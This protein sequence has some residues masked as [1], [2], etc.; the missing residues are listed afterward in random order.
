MIRNKMFIRL[1]YNLTED[2]PTDNIASPGI[3]PNKLVLEQFDDIKKRSRSNR[4]SI[5]FTSHVGTHIDSPYHF[6]ANGKKVADFSIEDYIFEKPLVVDVKKD[7]WEYII[8]SDLNLFDK[9]ITQC[10]LLMVRTMFSKYRVSDPV[11]YAT[12]NPGISA[13]TACYLMEK[14]NIRAIAIDTISIEF[15]GKY[16]HGFQAHRIFLSDESHSILLIE[17]VN[18]NFDFSGLARVIALPL[19]IEKVDGCP[20]TILAELR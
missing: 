11:R 9:D 15:E 7:N 20:C 5:Q 3:K 1:S 2:F 10:D 14:R 13:D 19:F 6:N 8:P 18:L 12:Q 17:D 16:D 4:F